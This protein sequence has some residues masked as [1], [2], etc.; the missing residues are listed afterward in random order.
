MVVVVAVMVVVVGGSNVDSVGGYWCF[1]IPVVVTMAGAEHPVSM[2]WL[3]ASTKKGEKYRRWG[4]RGNVKVKEKKDEDEE[5]EEEVE[6]E[7]LQTGRANTFFPSSGAG[8][9][10]NISPPS[11]FVNEEKEKSTEIEDETA[12]GADVLPASP[13]QYPWCTTN[14]LANIIDQ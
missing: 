12:I 13:F 5:E 4:N 8:C 3:F 9:I 10:C 1:R 7:G 6:V 14:R 11:S 2:V